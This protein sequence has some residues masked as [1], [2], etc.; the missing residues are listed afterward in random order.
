MSDEPNR[1]PFKRCESLVGMKKSEYD[2]L[3]AERDELRELVE[4]VEYLE[5]WACMTGDCGHDHAN[6][7][8]AFMREHL[9][10]LASKAAAIINSPEGWEGEA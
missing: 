9:E 7:C 5:Y 3:V 1:V 8:L 10:G 2:A 6:D 4:E